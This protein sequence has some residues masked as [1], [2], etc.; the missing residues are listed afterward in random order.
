MKFIVPTLQRGNAAVGA[1][2]PSTLTGRWSVRHGIATLE[3]SN[4]K[5]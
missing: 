4:D 3:R 1:P 2:A 5:K